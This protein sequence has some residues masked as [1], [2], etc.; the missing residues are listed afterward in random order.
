[1]IF[2]SELTFENFYQPVGNPTSEL[3]RGVVG[4]DKKIDH[5]LVP[6]SDDILL[7]EGEG[8]EGGV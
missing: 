3:S 8:L 4:D 6:L 2:N 7:E 1:V 5:E